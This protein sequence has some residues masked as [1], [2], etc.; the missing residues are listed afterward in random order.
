MDAIDYILGEHT[1]SFFFIFSFLYS[2]QQIKVIVDG[3]L[4]RP[5]ILSLCH[6]VTSFPIIFADAIDAKA[7]RWSKTVHSRFP[8]DGA[9]LCHGKFLPHLSENRVTRFGEFSPLWHH[10]KKLWLFWKSSFSIGQYLSEILNCPMQMSASVN[11]HSLLL[12]KL[13]RNNR[14]RDYWSGLGRPGESNFFHGSDL[15]LSQMDHRAFRF[16]TRGQCIKGKQ[17]QHIAI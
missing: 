8:A 17:C 11:G 5:Y 12:K 2:W 9:K 3:S 14:D 6:S 4:M 1:G 15:W 13:A 7:W 10:V 16:A